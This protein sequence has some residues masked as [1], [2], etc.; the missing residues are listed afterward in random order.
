MLL[1]FRVKNFRS[2]RDEAVLNLLSSGSDKSMLDTNCIKTSI[3]NLPFA[4][5]SAVIYGAN[6]SGKT[7]VLQALNVMQKIVTQ[8]ASMQVGQTFNIQPFRL[9]ESC[10]KHPTEFEITFLLDNIRYQYGFTL[11]PE[12]ITGE[13]LLVY[14]AA[15]PQ[16]WITREF[17]SLN[18]SDNIELGSLLT[19]PKAIWKST[20][21]SNALFLSTAAQLNSEQLKPVFSWLSKNLLYFGAGELPDPTHTTNLLSIEDSKHAVHSFMSSADTGISGIQAIQSKV[22]Q[23]AIRF[24]P[25]GVETKSEEVDMSMPQFV[26]ETSDSAATFEFQDES[27][28]TQKLFLLAAPVLHVLKNGLTLVVDELESSLHPLLVNHIIGL[29]HDQ[30]QN[31]NGAQLIFTTHN[32]SLLNF[33]IFR[34]DQIWFSEKD[35]E[36][37]TKLYPLTDFS[38]RKN[39]A[40]ERGYLSG[41]Y[42]G[43]PFFSNEPLHQPVNL[44]VD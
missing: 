32:T 38:P 17:D 15:Q 2:I 8:S 20:T 23:Q 16:T 29:F 18:N 37:A 34:R 13:W 42:G 41:R 40:L 26:H 27:L 35:S 14:K 6:A 1:Q 21:R 39:E 44:K 22:T 9:N 4:L 10:K 30:K 43:V 24:G 28:G 19:G 33:D 11:T 5:K 25:S 7:N 3:K 31:Q 36:Q 12:R